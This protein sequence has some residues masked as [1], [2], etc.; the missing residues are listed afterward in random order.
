MWHNLNLRNGI[1]IISSLKP[2]MASIWTWNP[3]L[4]C[5]LCLLGLCQCILLNNNM[6]GHKSTATQD[7]Y[8]VAPPYLWGQSFCFSV[9]QD[10]VLTCRYNF[11]RN[12]PEIVHL[13]DHSSQVKITVHIE[14]WLSIPLIQ[15]YL[16]VPSEITVHIELWLSIPFIQTYLSVGLPSEITVHIELTTIDT[17]LSLCTQWSWWLTVK[18]HQSHP[19]RFTQTKWFLS[20]WTHSGTYTNIMSYNNM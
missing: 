2:I 16:S 11:R 6:Q 19:N 8:S 17:N 1:I 12:D 4:G 3:V 13:L 9:C 7:W 15:T 5:K 18:A 10:G 14:L 20:M